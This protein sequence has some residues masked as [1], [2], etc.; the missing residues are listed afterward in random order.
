MIILMMLLGAL[1]YRM[2]GG[3]G[4]KL[5]RPV[6][7]VL[8]SIPYVTCAFLSQDIFNFDYGQY[9]AAFLVLITTTAAV[10]TG[11][12]GFMDL[13]TWQNDRDDER[14]EFIIKPLHKKIPE[15]WYDSL[16][17]ALTG[18]VVT[19]PAAIVTLNPLLAITGVLKAPAYMLAQRLGLGTEGGEY[20]TG[21]ALWGSLLCVI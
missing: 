1:I 8:F 17:M 16:G 4:P 12:G 11:H 20:L 2:R 7:Q 15:Y 5:P 19:L 18:V 3:L 10:A 9:I 13:G 6:Y 14:L 21:A